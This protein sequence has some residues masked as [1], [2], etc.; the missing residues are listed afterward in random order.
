MRS[1][2]LE[3]HFA[4]ARHPCPDALRMQTP[5]SFI[6]PA[7]SLPPPA[8]SY[9]LLLTACLARVRYSQ[10]RHERGVGGTCR[11]KRC[12]AGLAECGMVMLERRWS[13]SSSGNQRWLV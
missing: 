6:P 9:S 3:V 8:C 5:V 7:S 13:M 4:P 1:L 10:C 2:L 12:Q 11:P